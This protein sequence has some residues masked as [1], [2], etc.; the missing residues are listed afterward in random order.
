VPYIAPDA[1]EDLLPPTPQLDEESPFATMMSLF[2]EAAE[3]LGIDPNIYE[4]LRRPDREVTYSVPIKLDSGRTAVFES[5]RVQ[6]NQGLGPFL[7][8]LRLDP[9]LKLDDLRALAGYMTWKC[10]LIGI[11][12]GGAAGGIRIS[13][14]LRSIAE[15]ER[16]VRRYT[17]GL[18]DMIGANTDIFAP[19]VATDERVMAWVMDTVSEHMRYTETGVVTGK[20]LIM[21]GTRGLEDGAAQGLRTVVRLALEHRQ[22]PTELRPS[23]IIQGAG[24]VGGNLARLLDES[25]FAVTGLSDNSGGYYNQK[26]LPIKEVLAWRNQN[27]T[28]EGS[29]SFGAWLSND[30]LLLQACDVLVPCA[31]A[32]TIRFEHAPKLKTKL[33]VE[34]AHGPVSV[35]ADRVLAERGIP[36]VPDILANAGGVLSNYFEWVQN[37]QGLTWLEEVVEK[38]RKRFMTEAWHATDHLAKEKKIRLRAAAHMLAVG[39]VAKADQTRGTYA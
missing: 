27:G 16:A 5:F 22:I 39:R 38:R 26:G 21:S 12:F 19:D 1:G 17:A 18:L 32:N 9:H 3:K 11:P 36:C 4:I 13:A 20:P 28:L 15:L 31:T 30:E 24:R 34:G 10:A 2:D 7:G 25:G 8:P 14:K 29:K 33:I 23:V 37:R 35:R 6:H